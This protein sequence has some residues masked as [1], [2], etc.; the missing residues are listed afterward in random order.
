M[1]KIWFGLVIG[2]FLINQ[3]VVNA[4]VPAGQCGW[5]GSNCQ[6]STMGQ[7][8]NA[9][10]LPP[11]G[12]VCVAQG[13]GCVI[14]DVGGTTAS[15]ITPGPT[16]VIAGEGQACG[17]VAG[18]MC[19]SGLKCNK[20]LGPDASGICVKAISG[21]ANDSGKVDL[22]DFDI[23]K[24]EYLGTIT[25][26]TADFNSDGVVNL[27]DFDIWKIAYLAGTPPIVVLGFDDVPKSY[28][29]VDQ[30]M[31]IRGKNISAGCGGNNYCPDTNVTRA[32]AAV[33]LV[34]AK[35]G[36]TFTPPV[37]A[38]TFA[39]VPSSHWAASWIEK[40]ATDGIS[41]GCSVGNFCPDAPVTRAQMAVFLVKNFN[42][43]LN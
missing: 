22:T 42:L 35:Y 26:K 24:R 8:C 2:L 15:L 16:I 37:V 30:I 4:I 23:W 13:G 33:M 40:L 5:C 43:T 38:S 11:E 14:S 29:A 39:D 36:S 12:K 21:D 18:I 9:D 28:W 1:N 34:K 27:T 3:G 6:I 32:Q 7:L 41:G 20:G 17:G 31:I 19:A 10:N 25:T